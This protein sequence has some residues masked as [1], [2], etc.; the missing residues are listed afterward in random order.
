M[1]GVALTIIPDEQIMLTLLLPKPT[2]PSRQVGWQSSDLHPLLHE[3]RDTFAP[4]TTRA[5]AR[6]AR[7]ACRRKKVKMSRLLATHIQRIWPH[8]QAVR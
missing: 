6:T 3:L 8:D 2:P 5:Q 1:V 4:P 7:V